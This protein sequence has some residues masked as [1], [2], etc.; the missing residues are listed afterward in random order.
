MIENSIIGL[1]TVPVGFLPPAALAGMP[2]GVPNSVHIEEVSL[3]EKKFNLDESSDEGP[4]LRKPETKP[5]VIKR[6]R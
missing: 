3:D 5:S 6:G 4:E 1:A 2:A